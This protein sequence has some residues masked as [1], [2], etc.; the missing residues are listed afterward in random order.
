MAVEVGSKAPEFHA[1]APD[2]S[3]VA[4][5]AF[6]GK[7]VVLSFFPAAFSGAPDDGCE[8][9]LCS[10]SALAATADKEKYVFYGISGD[11][12]FAN[13]AFGKKL[14]LVFPLLSDPTLATCDRYVGKCEFGEFFAKHGIS[15]ALKGAVCTNRGCVILD[16][17]GKVVYSFSG[18]GHPGEQPDMAVVRKLIV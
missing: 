7:T 5:E 4:N 17:E 15:T 14:E 12:P 16:P 3:A 6:A 10:M 11:L 18:N 2:L 8:M 9:Q 13:K 1:C